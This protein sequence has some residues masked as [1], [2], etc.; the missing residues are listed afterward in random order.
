MLEAVR[1]PRLTG[2]PWRPGPYGID[3]WTADDRP[4][5]LANTFFDLDASYDN[6]IALVKERCE[7]V[8]RRVN[9]H[10]EL[11]S[12]L[13]EMI[14]VASEL[15]RKIDWTDNELESYRFEELIA[16]AAKALDKVKGGPA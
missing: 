3:V 6:R 4:V 10:E 12:R 11:T 14:A 2:L 1:S 8:V 13:C 9:S 16:L 15:Y 5:L 7:E